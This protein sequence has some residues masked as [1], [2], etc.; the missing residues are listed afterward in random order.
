[1]NKIYDNIVFTSTNNFYLINLFI[2]H[3]NEK[4]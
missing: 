4:K 2:I 1:M 3:K